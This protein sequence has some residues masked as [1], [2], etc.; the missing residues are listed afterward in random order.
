MVFV[1]RGYDTTF[2]L[3]DMGLKNR[4]SHRSIAFNKFADFF[5]KSQKA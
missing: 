5:L 4:I 1:P 3:M 2:S